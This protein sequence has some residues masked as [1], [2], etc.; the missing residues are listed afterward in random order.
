M[1]N[2]DLAPCSAGRIMQPDRNG[3][4]NRQVSSGEILDQKLPNESG[5]QA[6][7]S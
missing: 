6:F 1:G 2:F 5:L 3:D 7:P 4:A